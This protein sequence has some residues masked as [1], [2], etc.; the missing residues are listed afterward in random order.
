MVENRLSSLRSN[1]FE[2]THVVVN[3]LSSLRSNCF[4]LMHAFRSPIKTRSF[5]ARAKMAE[6]TQAELVSPNENIQPE[7]EGGQSPATS[8]TIQVDEDLSLESIKMLIHEM[9]DREMTRHSSREARERMREI[10]QITEQRDQDQRRLIDEIATLK[11]KVDSLTTA[12]ARLA[13][14]TR[15]M[16]A[17]AFQAYPSLTMHAPPKFSA[18][19]DSKLS[20]QAFLRSY[21]AYIKT[22][23]NSDP[24]RAKQFIYNNLEGLAADWYYSEITPVEGTLTWPQIEQK[25]KDRFANSCGEQNAID[26]AYHREQGITESVSKYGEEIHALMTYTNMSED[27]KVLFF[28]KGLRPGLKKLVTGKRPRSFQEAM[29]LA[30][31]AERIVSAANSED[32][33]KMK[34]LQLLQDSSLSQAKSPEKAP[35]EQPSQAANTSAIPQTQGVLAQATVGP[36]QQN[37]VQTYRGNFSRPFGGGPAR[38]RAQRTPPPPYQT[39]A[40]RPFFQSQPM[41]ARQQRFTGPPQQMRGS[42]RARGLYRGF[43]RNQPASNRSGNYNGSQRQNYT[44]KDMYEFIKTFMSSMASRGRNR[45]G[46][47]TAQRGANKPALEERRS[48]PAPQSSE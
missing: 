25:L 20:I 46:N 29:E 41:Y 23:F 13:P 35:T 45:R 37:Y 4:E 10:E 18:S 6:A 33:V 39:G 42:G 8:D 32:T 38:Y 19:V 2:L 1:C 5:T 34:I 27:N 16:H 26:K 9:F 22:A 43:Y 30:I 15:G 36:Y 48:A 40:A 14:T 28:V 44:D 11:S 24:E 17:Q 31:D 47:M 12:E 3:R 7:P 21:N